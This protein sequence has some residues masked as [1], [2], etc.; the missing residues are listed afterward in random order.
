MVKCPHLWCGTLVRRR[1]KLRQEKLVKVEKDLES[2]ERNHKNDT[3]LDIVQKIRENKNQINEIYKVD[4]QKKLIFLKQRHYETGSKLT[5][6]GIQIK[7]ATSRER[8]T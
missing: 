4:I 7:K 2:L 6:P 8:N 5:A 1:K 3:Q